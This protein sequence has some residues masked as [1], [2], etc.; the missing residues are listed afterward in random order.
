[1]ANPVVSRASLWF[2]RPGAIGDPPPQTLP[3]LIPLHE[4]SLTP[5]RP[6]AF[7]ALRHSVSGYR[8]P[9]AAGPGAANRP[10]QDPTLALARPVP[11]RN[12]IR[13]RC[14]GLAAR[15]HAAVGRAV[16]GTL[17]QHALARRAAPGDFLRDGGDPAVRRP[18]GMDV[19]G[20]I[21][22]PLQLHR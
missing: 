22:D 2:C 20:G 21:R 10:G 9:D 6:P 5:F 11:A 4:I 13:L 1:M 12:R 3:A 17:A 14:A 15:A 16:A 19:L 18:V 8:Q 7:P